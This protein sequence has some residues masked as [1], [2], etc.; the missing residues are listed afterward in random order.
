[1]FDHSWLHHNLQWIPELLVVSFEMEFFASTSSINCGHPV[2]CWSS[3]CEDEELGV[4][5]LTGDVSEIVIPT[6]SYR[7][8]VPHMGL[9]LVSVTS[10]G[11]VFYTNLWLPSRFSLL[12]TYAASLIVVVLIILVGK[13]LDIRKVCRRQKDHYFESRHRYDPLLKLWIIVMLTS[14]VLW[15]FEFTH[16]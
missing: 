16:W 8:G 12:Y 6:A 14:F 2:G 4:G 1:V 3:D 7:M 13:L 10:Q 11:D 9:G 15:F 5:K